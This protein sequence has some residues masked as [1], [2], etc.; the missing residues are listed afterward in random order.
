MPRLLC[1]AVFYLLTACLTVTKK[2][3]SSAVS[4]N[5]NTAL[6]CSTK[7]NDTKLCNDFV[8][9]QSYAGLLPDGG[10]LE[11]SKFY[12]YWPDRFLKS[13]KLVSVKSTKLESFY[14]LEIVTNIDE[15]NRDS[16]LIE[17]SS[18][19]LYLKRQTPILTF[20]E[21]SKIGRGDFYYTKIEAIQRIGQ[22]M[23]LVDFELRDDGSCS[24]CQEISEAID[25]IDAKGHSMKVEIKKIAEDLY[26]FALSPEAELR[27]IKFNA[28]KASG[29]YEV[30]VNPPGA[31]NLE[32]IFNH[33]DQVK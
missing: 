5:F 30:L 21:W 4:I 29:Y 17:G 3:D 12:I 9:L 15:I 11:G 13:S 25:F 6:E 32:V 31:R 8:V 23:V 24:A 20:L 22:D 16:F 28:V 2:K 10:L 33:E 26:G 18:S 7:K 27:K 14:I 19:Q 1:F